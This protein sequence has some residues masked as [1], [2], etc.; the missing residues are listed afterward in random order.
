MQ[1]VN[2]ENFQ[3]EVLESSKPVVVDIWGPSCEPC[4]ALLPAVEELSEKY[5]EEVKIVKLNSAENR[6]LCID[7]KVIGLPTF[8]LFQGGKEVSRI[9]GK[10]VDIE[11]IEKLIRDIHSSA[12][13]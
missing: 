9:S 1:A 13:N 5:T 6:R 12:N 7:L 2:K 8:L 10:D 11:S 4:I 3:T